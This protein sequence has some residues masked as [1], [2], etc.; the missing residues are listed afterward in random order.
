MSY[1]AAAARTRPRAAATSQVMSAS[2]F[3][4]IWNEPIFSPNASR[5]SA[6]SSAASRHACASPTDRAATLSRP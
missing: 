4:T 6:Y 3:L 5:W 1:F 2:C